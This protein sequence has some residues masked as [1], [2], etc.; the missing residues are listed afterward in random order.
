GLQ[1][2]DVDAVEA[3][4][5]GTTLG[6]PIEAQALLGTYGKGRDADRPLWLGSLKSNIGHTQAA[7][8]VGGVI[9][10]VQAIRHGLLPRTL[11]VDQP[12]SAVDWTEG[13]V[14]LLTEA[15]EWPRTSTGGTDVDG[16]TDQAAGSDEQSEPTAR[17]RRAAVSA[18]GVSGT[19]AHA[20]IEQAPATAAEAETEADS[21]GD[22]PACP[23]PYLPWAL[24]ARTPE[25]LAAQAERLLAYVQARPEAGSQ[26]VARALVTTRT[27]FAERA[28]VWGADRAELG[29][30]LA[31]VAAGESAANVVRGVARRGGRV[32]FVFAG[33]GA[34]RW[35]MG[36]E[37]YAAFPVFADAFD[38]VCARLDGELDRPL[39]DVVFGEDAEAGDG[40]GETGVT[41][42]ALFA[43]E[44]ALF[45][46]VESWGVRPD[47]LLGHSIGELAA[48]YVAG[49]WSLE[50]ACVVVAARGRLMQALPRDGA[51]VAIEASEAEV[52]SLLVG[53]A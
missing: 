32:G 34:Q 6:D 39:R 26:D 4:G 23:L 33:Q 10:M 45:R 7:A 43:F 29:A 35:G 21:A 51:M 3:H 44:V 53:R 2:G 1:P 24:S 47:V 15:C 20:I 17:P 8:G 49:V 12:A 11:H 37:L 25:A 41:Q 46:L 38:E 28:V 27:T 52:A 19:N 22:R 50:D 36:R 16:D 48:A 42:P 30:G 31:A 14:R 5:T 13:E 9:K 40:L 18:F